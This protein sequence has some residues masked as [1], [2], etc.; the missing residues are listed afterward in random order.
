MS[1]KTG[2]ALATIP[3]KNPFLVKVLCFLC[4]HGVCIIRPIPYYGIAA[5]A[6]KERK[7]MNVTIDIAPSPIIG[8]FF[9]VF[10][11]SFHELLARVVRT[12]RANANLE[13]RFFSSHLIS[14]L[15]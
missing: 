10:V 14:S 8:E 3:L 15:R 9:R 1:L 6:A 2:V 11:Y 4:V 7:S 12:V 13:I 5:I